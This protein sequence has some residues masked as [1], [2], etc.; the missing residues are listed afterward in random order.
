MEAVTQGIKHITTL[1]F[2]RGDVATNPAENVSALLGAKAARYLQL[3]L[4]APL[5]RASFSQKAT[6]L[7][8][9]SP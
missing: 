5:L 3:G 6:R 9:G 4:N 2:R 8:C 1:F 7:N